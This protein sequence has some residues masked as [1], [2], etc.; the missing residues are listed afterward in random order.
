MLRLRAWWTRLRCRVFGHTGVF[1]QWEWKPTHPQWKER[2]DAW[3]C[4]RCG[5]DVLTGAETLPQFHAPRPYL[6]PEVIEYVNLAITEYGDEA[7]R[8]RAGEPEGL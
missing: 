4:V 5:E 8:I 3:T 1:R 2:T 7:V 6:S